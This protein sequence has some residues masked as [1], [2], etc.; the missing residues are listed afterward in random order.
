MP[1]NPTPRRIGLVSLVA[2][3]LLSAGLAFAC[4]RDSTSTAELPQ[5]I[6]TRAVAADLPA[7]YKDGVLSLTLPKKGN[8]SGRRISIG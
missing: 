8:G 5:G 6:E 2:A 1:R 3:L 4:K 7:E